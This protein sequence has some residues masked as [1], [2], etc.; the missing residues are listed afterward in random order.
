MTVDTD[1]IPLY[2]QFHATYDEKDLLAALEPVRSTIKEK[3][4]LGGGQ[5]GLPDFVFGGYLLVLLLLLGSL[6]FGLYAML[7]SDMQVMCTSSSVYMYCWHIRLSGMLCFALLC[8]TNWGGLP[9]I[10]LALLEGR[11]MLV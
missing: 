11:E 1:L 10:C 2:V 3:P 9:C 4:F 7:T 8:L 5:A 6:E